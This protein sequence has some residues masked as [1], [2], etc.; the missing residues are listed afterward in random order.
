[1]N[2]CEK[3]R[4]KCLNLQR[5]ASIFKQNQ[6]D[7]LGSKSVTFP[8]LDHSIWTIDARLGYQKASISFSEENARHFSWIYQTPVCGC[9]VGAVRGA[10]RGCGCGSRAG[11]ILPARP[12][13]N[14]FVGWVQNIKIKTKISDIFLKMTE[15]NKTMKW[16]K[17]YLNNSSFN[18][19]RL[20]F[21]SWQ[22]SGGTFEEVD[23]KASGAFQRCQL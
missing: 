10:V 20:I 18:F 12:S 19:V 3:I 4:S 17:I 9:G 7:R 5:I 22:S 11:K 15:L 23:C 14:F 2:L 6:R 21:C 1:M 13:G 8:H 16:L